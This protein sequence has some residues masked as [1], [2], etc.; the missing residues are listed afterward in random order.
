VRLS[1]L[2]NAALAY[3]SEA[4]VTIYWLSHETK[5]SEAVFVVFVTATPNF[6]Y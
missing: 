2:T 4:A 6:N 1:L 3:Y 5:W